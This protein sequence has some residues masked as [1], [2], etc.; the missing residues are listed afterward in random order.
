MHFHGYSWTGDKN[1]FDKE[2]LR[3]VP[4]EPWTTADPDANAQR[5]AAYR[6]LSEDFQR[7]EL[8]P[9]RTAYWLIKSPR[10]I[11][12]TWEDAGEA[13]A[14]LGGQLAE[15]GEWFAS[16]RDAEPKRRAR[17]VAQAAERLA[18]GE[19][20]SYGFYLRQPSFLS[21]AVVAC[22]PNKDAP[23]LPCPLL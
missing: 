23:Q 17:L 11:R 3:R 5:Q 13:A 12:G 18:R 6:T 9:M 7:S 22:S 10:L 8:P 1:H 14:W 2:W 19:D 21:L 20:V 4:D 15:S 16:S